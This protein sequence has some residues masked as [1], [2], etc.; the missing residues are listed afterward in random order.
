MY[1]YLYIIAV[2]DIKRI[3]THLKE[4]MTKDMAAISDVDAIIDLVAKDAMISPVFLK[5]SDD[6][7]TILKKLRHEDIQACIVLDD[8]GIFVWEISVEDIIKLLVQ[9]LNKEP[10][11]KYLTRGY[12]KWLLYK[13][14][15]SL[16]NKHRC[17]VYEDTNINTIIRHIYKPWFI[18]VPVIDKEKKV[19]GVVTP[20]SL[21][22]LLKDY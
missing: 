14:A 1:I 22:K 8:D 9:Q 11:I 4:R 12:K 13:N 17:V 6:I 5:E 10:M 2:M 7:D 16:C 20:S 19:I 3:G 18:Y 21:I 15:G